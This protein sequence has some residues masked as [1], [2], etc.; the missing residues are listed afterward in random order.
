MSLF[1][2]VDII[3]PVW[4]QLGF[5]KRCIES[6]FKNTNYVFCLIVIDNASS[7]PTRDYLAQ[8]ACDK[9]EIV[10]LIRNDKNLGFVKA[11]NQ[12]IKRS[13]AP[14][15]CLLNNDTEVTKGWLEE[16]IKV[17]EKEKNIGIVNANSNTLG[18]K[19]KSWQSLESLADELKAHS[20]EYTTLAWAT[21]FCM[22]IKR[23]VINKIGLF[24]EIY[25]MGNFEDADFSK[26]AQK[27]GYSS[28]CAVASYVYHKERRSFVRFKKFNQDFDRNREI[29]YSKWGR[30]KR[31]LYVLTKNDAAGREA[32]SEKSFI[33]A[34]AGHIVWIFLKEKDR[35]GIKKHSNIYVYNIPERFFEVASL[36]RIVK[37]KKRFDRI[38]VDDENYSE[39]LKKLSILHKAEVV[40]GF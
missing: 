7:Q 3:I 4:D 1:A 14:Y 11:V 31:I 27:A 32:V 10:T 26:R 17:A 28:V 18:C 37:R 8:L 9:K 22:L 34:S 30:Q 36:W 5:T 29:F 15:V 21:G 39:K 35:G 20:G 19:L 16:M 23:E 13:S 33:S 2:K 24:D 6:V 40:Y 38:N 12:G 25:G